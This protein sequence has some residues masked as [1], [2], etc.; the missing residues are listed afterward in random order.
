MAAPV[1]VTTHP[2]YYPGE[3]L[4]ILITYTQPGTLNFNQA[5]QTTY[6]LD[7]TYSARAVG[8]SFERLVGLASSAP[9]TM[10]GQARTS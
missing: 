5:P 2:T 6:Q 1:Q 7:G 10:C 8:N 3:R 4:E 9:P